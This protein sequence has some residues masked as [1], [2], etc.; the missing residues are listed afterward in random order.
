M[1]EFICGFPV[2]MDKEGK[3]H[4]LFRDRYSNTNQLCLKL[5]CLENWTSR[6]NYHPSIELTKE[7]TY[8][9]KRESKCE[10]GDNRFYVPDSLIE[11][12]EVYQALHTLA[13][14]IGEIKLNGALHCICITKS[15]IIQRIPYIND[16]NFDEQL[17]SCKEALNFDSNLR[18]AIT[19]MVLKGCQETITGDWNVDAKDIWSL[20]G[21]DLSDEEVR[22]QV[23]L[24][25]SL[26]FKHG[27]LASLDITLNM[28]SFKFFLEYCPNCE[29]FTEE[30]YM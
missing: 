10:L 17:F 23:F 13:R 19:E 30:D 2:V 11:R 16:D 27:C 14:G 8:I 4:A 5:L 20:Y 21:I 9:E 29:N 25:T 7:I 1:T 15:E 26:L 22:N 24:C 28:I 6:G 18:S 12:E 3:H